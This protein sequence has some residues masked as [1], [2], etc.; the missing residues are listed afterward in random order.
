[1]RPSMLC[2]DFQN[3]MAPRPLGRHR[4][5]LVCMFYGSVDTISRQQNFEIRPM[6]CVGPPLNYLVVLTNVVN[7]QPVWVFTDTKETAKSCFGCKLLPNGI[8]DFGL[9]N[10]CGGGGGLKLNVLS[11]WPTADCEWGCFLCLSVYR[12][13][14]VLCLILKLL[15]DEMLPLAFTCSMINSD[16]SLVSK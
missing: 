10:V 16:T 1:M 7:K 4:C 14:A 11:R 8:L 6:N 3:P 5:N 13:K 12:L 15:I 2:Q 9:Y